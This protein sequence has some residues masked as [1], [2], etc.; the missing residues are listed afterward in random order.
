VWHGRTVNA[1]QLPEAAT[2]QPQL[3]ASPYV[4]KRGFAARWQFSTRKV[5]SLLAAGMPHLKIGS[6]RI[7]IVTSEADA[8]MQSQFRVQRRAPAR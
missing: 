8:W 3:A 1:I 2:G 5:D 7:R 6:R 4:D